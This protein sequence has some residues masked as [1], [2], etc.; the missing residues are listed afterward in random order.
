MAEQENL[1][2]AI[3]ETV[4]LLVA[5][6]EMPEPKAVAKRFHENREE[7]GEEVPAVGAIRHYLA[8]DIDFS[9]FVAGTCTDSEIRSYLSE[10]L[11][12]YE[13]TEQ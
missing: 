13:D 2:A 1:L 12:C 3:G 5:R 9:R 6:Y 7:I 8:T 11:K 10:V 4:Y